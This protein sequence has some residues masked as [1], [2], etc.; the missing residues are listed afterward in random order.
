L[1]P[2]GHVPINS[3]AVQ[4]KKKEP[5]HYSK[6][7]RKEELIRK[8]KLKQLEWMKKLYQYGKRI[9]EGL[10]PSKPLLDL[11]KG[12]DVD[13]DSQCESEAFPKPIRNTKK[14]KNSLSSLSAVEMELNTILADMEQQEMD[15]KL[16]NWT[17][18][19]DYDDYHATW[20]GLAAT[21]PSDIPEALEGNPIRMIC[22]SYETEMKE[23]L[24]N[25]FDV[26]LTQKLEPV[27]ERDEFS[28]AESV[29]LFIQTAKV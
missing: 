19:L 18:A 13:M 23:A 8:R 10:E 5:F 25:E 24:P 7:K 9:E 22:D 1:E 20:L 16:I 27:A 3:I 17:R 12:L 4:D 26:P 28:D 21:A 11:Q 2:L 15:L 14:K 29:N 6:L